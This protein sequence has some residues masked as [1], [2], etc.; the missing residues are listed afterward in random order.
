MW[1]IKFYVIFI[2]LFIFLRTAVAGE[3]FYNLCVLNLS[4][5]GLSDD[6]LHYLLNT[7]PPQSIIVLEDIDCAINKTDSKTDVYRVIFYIFYLFFI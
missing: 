2:L 7:A 3:I 5:R 6:R 1:K 4:E